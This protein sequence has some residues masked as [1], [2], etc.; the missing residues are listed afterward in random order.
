MKK[1]SSLILVYLVLLAAFT[2]AAFLLIEDKDSI[3]YISYAAILIGFSSVFLGPVLKNKFTAAGPAVFFSFPIISSL[4]LI[5]TII[6][7][8]LFGVII[9]L[10]TTA[11]LCLHIITFALFIAVSILLSYLKGNINASEHRDKEFTIS[12]ELLRSDLNSI[13]NRIKAN[14]NT[15]DSNKELLNRLQKTYELLRYSDPISNA[16][17]SELDGEIR[18]IISSISDKSLNLHDENISSI[19]NDLNI[20]DTLILERNEKIKILKQLI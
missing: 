9:K 19:I 12:F 2:L 1:R 5:L 15:G 6:I 17:I 20:L 16:K 4:Y 10:G 7:T 3:F 13:I 11:Y 8:L 18:Q 14:D